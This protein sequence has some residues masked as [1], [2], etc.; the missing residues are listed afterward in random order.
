MS[1]RYRR[2]FEDFERFTDTFLHF[3]RSEISLVF[4]HIVLCLP[5]DRI[6]KVKAIEPCF[7][8]IILLV[9]WQ[10]FLQFFQTDQTFIFWEYWNCLLWQSWEFFVG[11]VSKMMDFE[12]GDKNHFWERE[13]NKSLKNWFPSFFSIFDLC[14][15][16]LGDKILAYD[17]YIFSF[18]CISCILS[19][20]LAPH[21]LV[22]LLIHIAQATMKCLI[23]LDLL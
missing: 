19:L 15:L 6:L 3:Y 17:S 21:E 18:K 5:E 13:R 8:F 23:L 16:S 14:Y 20:K 10:V 9:S 11:K 12:F 22:T 4:N 1:N 2:N 7:L